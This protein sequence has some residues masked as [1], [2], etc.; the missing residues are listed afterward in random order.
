MKSRENL[1]NAMQPNIKFNINIKA[2]IDTIWFIFNLKD[3]TKF[4]NVWLKFTT[5]Y[6][7]HM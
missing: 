2:N 5:P 7:W 4:L 6:I 1:K 3:N